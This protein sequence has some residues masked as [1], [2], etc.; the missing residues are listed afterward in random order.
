MYIMIAYLIAVSLAY[1]E[2]KVVGAPWRGPWFSLLCL[3][4]RQTVAQDWSE[5]DKNESFSFGGS[6]IMIAVESEEAMVETLEKMEENHV[7]DFKLLS[8]IKISDFFNRFWIKQTNQI[9]DK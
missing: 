4:W 9:L 3:V 2:R 1:C 8:E 5:D 6:V 7:Y